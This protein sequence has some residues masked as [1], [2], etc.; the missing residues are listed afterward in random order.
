MKAI[1]EDIN[2]VQRRIKVTVPSEDVNRSFQSY[3]QKART[4]AK[5]PGFRQG[6]VPLTIVKKM[7]GPSAPYDIVDQLIR[8]HLLSSIR[9]TGVRAI[10][11]PYVES[12]NVPVEDKPYEII[13][14]V[15]VLPERHG[16]KFDGLC[17][18][19]K[20]VH[21]VYDII[22]CEMVFYSQD[23]FMNNVGSILCQNVD[24]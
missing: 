2:S 9:E 6:K 3:F 10:S 14:I 21:S 5:V 20:Y 15:D 24:T 23:P 18:C 17:H 8:E 13:A 12:S 16:C 11:Q 1:V 22:N 4:K 7:Y 19:G